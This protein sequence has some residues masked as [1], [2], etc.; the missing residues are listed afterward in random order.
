MNWLEFTNQMTSN[1]SWP[2]TV[3]ALTFILRTP[4]SKIVLS[5][6]KVKIKDIE[7]DFDK[8]IKSIQTEISSKNPNHPKARSTEF[9]KS[10]MFWLVEKSPLAIILQSWDIF[11]TTIFRVSNKLSG[12]SFTHVN[13][14]VLWLNENNEDLDI[15]NLYYRLFALKTEVTHFES[16]VMSK[17]RALDMTNIILEVTQIVERKS[18]KQAVQVAAQK[19]RS[20]G[21]K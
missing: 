5:L 2:L 16:E 21:P 3:I 18:E 8:S 12:K 9:L 13:E 7:I 17:N 6:K 15:V 10:N 4:L 19:T 1:L 14:A 11:E 20:F